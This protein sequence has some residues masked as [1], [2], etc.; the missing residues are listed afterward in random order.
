MHASERSLET[1][2][3]EGRTLWTWLQHWIGPVEQEPSPPRGTMDALVAEAAE[4]ELAWWR[5][6]AGR[7]LG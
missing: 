1:E 5:G 3:G 7:L 4:R 6:E 2:A